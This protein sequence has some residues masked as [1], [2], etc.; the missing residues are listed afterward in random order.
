MCREM[1]P[2][3]TPWS[4]TDFPLCRPL[5]IAAFSGHPHVVKT[6]YEAGARLDARNFYMKTA[7]HSAAIEG[8]LESAKMLTG[9]CSLAEKGAKVPLRAIEHP[10]SG[11]GSEDVI[12]DVDKKSQLQVSNI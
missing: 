5:H 9:L 2:K 10:I 6:L 1:A 11:A 7:L 8:E 12:I 3:F 4:I